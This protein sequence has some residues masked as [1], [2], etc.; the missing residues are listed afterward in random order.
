MHFNAFKHVSSSAKT[1]VVDWIFSNFDECFAGLFI[2]IFASF[3]FFFSEE[4]FIR[5]L[6]RS[7]S[8]LPPPFPRRRNR[9]TSLSCSF[10]SS[11]RVAF[12]FSL[13][14]SSSSSS[15]AERRRKRLTPFKSSSAS[16]KNESLF[17]LSLLLII[18]VVREKNDDAFPPPNPPLLGAFRRSAMRGWMRDKERETK[19]DVNEILFIRG[20]NCDD[21]S[22]CSDCFTYSFSIRRSRVSF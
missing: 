17:V 1:H 22:C 7:L 6:S 11:V 10:S 9:R 8:S 21:K 5:S 2:G 4:T 12:S 19:S 20:E 13:S 15:L 14:S 3:A 16:S 18:I